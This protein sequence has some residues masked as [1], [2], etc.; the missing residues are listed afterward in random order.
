MFDRPNR[1]RSNS[2]PSRVAVSEP[3]SEPSPVS[4]PLRPPRNP[5]RSVLPPARPNPRA[6]PSTSSG[7]AD[8]RSFWDLS[9]TL[10]PSAKNPAVRLGAQLLHA[11]STDFSL[12]KRNKSTGSKT[13][14]VRSSPQVAETDDL[15]RAHVA[16]NDA[17]PAVSTS[18]HPPKSPRQ[19]EKQLSPLSTPVPPS[20]LLSRKQKQLQFS[21]ADRTILEELKRSMSA[22]AAQFVLKGSLGSRHHPYPPDVV[23]YPRSYTREAVDMFVGLSCCSRCFLSLFQG[24][25]GDRRLPADFFE[26]DIPCV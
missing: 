25:V 4:S 23:P 26:L 22:H 6:R 11:H 18:S 12:L 10:A 3:L 21:T 5:A 1:L 24:R 2:N 17:P 7:P 14:R 16:T 13:P 9:T 8:R 20:Q 19:P 15:R